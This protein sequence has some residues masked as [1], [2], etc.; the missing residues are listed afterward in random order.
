MDMYFDFLDKLINNDERQFCDAHI[1]SNNF[2]ELAKINLPSVQA[3]LSLSE[4]H[5][6]V[7]A[8]LPIPRYIRRTDSETVHVRC[9]LS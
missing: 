7:F 1:F 5:P 4:I 9:Y 8:G 6:F 2:P 3:P